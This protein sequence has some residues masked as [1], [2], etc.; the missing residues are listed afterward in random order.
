M[1]QFVLLTLWNFGEVGHIRELVLDGPAGGGVEVA[2]VEDVICSY[3]RRD[4]ASIP[5]PSAPMAATAGIKQNKKKE[6]A[7]ALLGFLQHYLW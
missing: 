3:W 7:R 1:Q 2:A 5:A 6:G 4:P